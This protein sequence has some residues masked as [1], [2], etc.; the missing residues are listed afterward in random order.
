MENEKT[1]EELKELKEKIIDGEELSQEE[2]DTIIA[3][4]PGD[5]DIPKEQNKEQ[6]E[7]I[8]ERIAEE[9]QK[10]NK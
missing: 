4:Y 9:H 8:D 7:K 2:L 5:F 6:I 10:M 3:G 1:I